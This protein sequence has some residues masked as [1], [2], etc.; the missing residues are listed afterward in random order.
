MYDAPQSITKA[1]E[2]QQIGKHAAVTLA[3]TGRFQHTTSISARGQLWLTQVAPST[4]LACLH[5]AN[6]GSW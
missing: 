1:R 4:L 3:H 5:V 2:H 6:S